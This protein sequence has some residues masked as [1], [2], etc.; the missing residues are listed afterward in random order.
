MP[1]FTISSL[2]IDDNALYQHYIQAKE[3]FLLHF[4]N[5][6][7][8]AHLK[9]FRKKAEREA[10][11]RS[12]PQNH[13]ESF[14]RARCGIG[15]EDI[16]QIFLVATRYRDRF[17]GIRLGANPTIEDYLVRWMSS[18]FTAAANKPRH[19]NASPKSTC[20][21]QAVST[22]VRY[23]Q[24][25][26]SIQVIEAE[27][28][29]NLFMSAEN[30]QGNLLEEYV[31]N[32]VRPYGFLWCRGSV[33]RA[34]DFCNTTGELLLQLKNK[35][36]SENSSS[37]NIREGTDITKWFRIGTS[38][39]SGQAIPYYN[40]C[41]LN[42]LISNHRTQGYTLENCH[43]SETDYLDFLVEISSANHQLISSL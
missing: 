6:E 24:N 25:M 15:F 36:N 12:F 38:R 10:R 32:K 42:C 34:V 3:T 8:K 39:Q 16:D 28:S 40:W 41:D 37:S 21:D 19:H 5:Q 26:T 7:K 30:I 1:N 33:L 13:D 22:I 27:R 23:S 43:M 4:Y 11:L 9:G 17:P 18:Y 35:D 14:L 31:A 2:Q 20:S 29:H